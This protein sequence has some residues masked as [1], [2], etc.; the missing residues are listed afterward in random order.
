ASASASTAQAKRKSNLKSKVRATQDG[1]QEASKSSGG[2]V[3]G[4]VDYVTLMMGGRRAAQTE[5][6]KIEQD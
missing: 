5:A 1:K 6:S 3:L 2:R 4:D